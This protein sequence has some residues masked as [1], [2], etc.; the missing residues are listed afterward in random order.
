MGFDR[1]DYGEV[2]FG[3]VFSN[4]HH[5]INDVSLIWC[6]C[7]VEECF[8]GREILSPR[9]G[10]TGQIIEGMRNFKKLEIFFVIEGV[11]NFTG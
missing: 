2:S 7:F 3:R 5:Q 8:S 11:R 6:F 10:N 1:T 4:V 9:W